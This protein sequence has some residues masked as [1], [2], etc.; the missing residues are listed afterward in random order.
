MHI[1]TYN[2]PDNPDNPSNP[3]NPPGPT[4]QSD[5]AASMGYG[6]TLFERLIKGSENKSEGS[7]NKK[8]IKIHNMTML[9]TQYRM[10]QVI[11]KWYGIS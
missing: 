1:I 8:H 2:N 11:M 3:D 10:N 6:E 9:T 4:L 5:R 7:E